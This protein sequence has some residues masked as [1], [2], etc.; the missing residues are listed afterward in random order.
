MT[1]AAIWVVAHGSVNDATVIEINTYLRSLRGAPEIKLDLQLPTGIDPKVHVARYPAPAHDR[2]YWCGCVTLLIAACALLPKF[3]C[4]HMAQF[5]DA[6][7][8]IQRVD[9][10]RVDLPASTNY[11]PRRL[12]TS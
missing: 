4:C 9:L 12:T 1:H 5:N 6:A 7:A 8:F 10:S 2:T 11:N 3:L